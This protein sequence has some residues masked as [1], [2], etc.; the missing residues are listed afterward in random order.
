MS[1]PPP[2]EPQGPPT[3]DPEGPQDRPPG[4]APLPQAPATPYNPYAPPSEDPYG[5]QPQPPYGAQPQPPYGAQPQTP[6]TPYPQGPPPPYGAQPY[7]TWPQGYSP[8]ANPA[9][10]NG[11]SVAALVLGILCC[12]PGVGLVLGLIGLNQTRKRGERGRSMAVTGIV[13]SSFGLVLWVLGVA[14]AAT[15]FFDDVKVSTGDSASASPVK[16][17]CF[18]APSGSLEG[19]A[20]DFD[21]VSCAG[22]HDAEVFAVVRMGGGSYPGDKKVTATADDRCYALQDS[23]A[24]DGWALPDDVDI[25]YVTPTEQ[26]WRLGDREITCAFGNTDEEASLPGGSLRNDATTL[27]ADQV[28]YLKAAHVL[29]AA[30]DSAPDAQYVED[31]LPGHKAWA[32]RVSA[33]LTQQA[34]LL[35]GHQW[36]GASAKPVADLVKDLRAAQKEWAKAAGASDADEFY[37]YYDKGAELIDPHLSVTARK[38]LG[39]ATTPPPYEEDDGGGDS[40]GGDTGL[41]V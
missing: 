16:G 26:S 37:G 18:D 5:A 28:A 14:G 7:P 39:L 21:V 34:D 41:E 30:L 1:I 9:P 19:M 29:N 13:L 27:D 31:D 32:G 3:P 35:E 20:Y 10:L 25:Y 8:Y 11:M 4:P 2:P 23:Y 15:G 33:A 22:E 24:M 17:E 38:A 36:P 40:G 12:V 6:Y